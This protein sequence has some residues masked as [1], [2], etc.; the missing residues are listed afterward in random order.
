M[1]GCSG[2]RLWLIIG[3]GL[4]LVAASGTASGQIRND[5]EL[6]SLLTAQSS[7]PPGAP[8][9]A[10]R[11]GHSESTEVVGQ[12]SDPKGGAASLMTAAEP[13]VQPLPLPVPE[14]RQH[15]LVSTLLSLS[16]ITWAMIVAAIAAFGALLWTATPLP[17]LV[18]GH[19]RSSKSV[20]FNEDQQR[21]VGHC[22]S[23]GKQLARREGVWKAAEPTWR[24]P[25]VVQDPPVDRS[26]GDHC[27][28]A[29]SSSGPLDAVPVQVVEWPLRGKSEPQPN[30]ERAPLAHRAREI[31]SRVADDGGTRA[32]PTPGTRGALF[33]VVDELRARCTTDEWT[34]CAE[35][36]SI[37]M[38]ELERALRHGD[39]SEATLARGDLK[40]LAG[41]WIGAR[42][43]ANAEAD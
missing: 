39:K 21:W 37:R 27:L 26:F 38:Q 4:T 18:L 19:R 33:S 12:P 22:K 1:S 42:A 30:H 16:P 23:C 35:K 43:P 14:S 9:K 34:L 32:T 41:K 11:P 2:M 15:T 28:V 20:R 40:A 13:V 8:T 31:V 17:C 10:V 5:D 29:G 24:K 6:Y 36:I 7:A 3:L 25:E